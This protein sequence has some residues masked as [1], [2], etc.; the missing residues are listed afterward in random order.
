MSYPNTLSWAKPQIPDPGYAKR[1]ALLHLELLSAH[2]I[3][4]FKVPIWDMATAILPTSPHLHPFDVVGCYRCF[5]DWCFVNGRIRTL[6][7]LR[8]LMMVPCFCWMMLF[9][10]GAMADIFVAVA[11]VGC[12]RCFVEWCF[13]N[14]RIRT[15]LLSCWLKVVPCSGWVRH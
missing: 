1:A 11:V 6:L 15:L 7:L 9:D 12:D 10:S 4:A 8:W 2:L 5:V 13:A 3:V 14:G